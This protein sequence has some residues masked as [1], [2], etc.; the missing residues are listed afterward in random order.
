M[1]KILK[2]SILLI[3]CYSIAQPTIAWQKCLGGTLGERFDNFQ[4]TSD[5]GYILIGTS[6]S[7]NG[8]VSGSYGPEGDIWVVKTNNLGILQWQKCLGGTNL[9]F[10]SFGNIKQTTDGG[11][12]LI[13][14]TRSIDGDVT[15]LHDNIGWFEDIWI[16]KL[17]NLGIIQWQKCI[18]GSGYDIGRDIIQTN[19]GGYIVVGE[20]SSND[21]DVTGNH[22]IDNNDIWVVKLTNNGVFQWKKCIGGT[23]HES[24][25]T[26]QQ[27]TDGGYILVGDTYSNDGDITGNHGASD[28]LVVKLSSTGAFQWKK[29]FGGSN[30]DSGT[31]I[32][33]TIDG[34][35]ILSGVTVSN[36]LEVSG[37]QGGRDGWI[38][39]ISNL[40]VVQWQKCLGGNNEDNI[41]SIIQT[42]DGGFAI[43]GYSNSINGDVLG[44]HGNF[45]GWIL[46]LTNTGTFQWQKCIGGT[47]GDYIFSMKQTSDGGYILS[48]GSNSND[49]DVSGNH[50]AN[51]AWVVKLSS[52]LG[53]DESLYNNLVSFSPNPVTN[54]LNVNVNDNMINQKYSITDI[55]G[56]LIVEGKLN[57]NSSS[58]N[59]EYLSKG[60]Y[61]L[62]VADNKAIKFI[63]E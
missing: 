5:G 36:D 27:T 10:A 63:K 26:I 45:D 62:K 54:I 56:K 60:V 24:V 61:F 21:G 22:N 20:T 13:G 7:N 17:S 44:N 35:Y 50:G 40:G 39:K 57:E 19:D 28:F 33:Q 53:M 46:K 4:Q 55:L 1:K 38:V 12:V 29:C 3:S 16:V 34:G 30:F 18:G 37:N 11:Y 52:V 58:I 48:G 47:N 23:D 9:D 25:M 42:Q 51:D 49:G 31:D 59:V 43:G 14:S 32:Q 41:Y 15:G 8:D 2:L 6:S